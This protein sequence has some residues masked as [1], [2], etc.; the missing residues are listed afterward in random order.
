MVLLIRYYFH[1]HY[2]PLPPPT[3]CCQ[4][5][6]LTMWKHFIMSH[7]LFLIMCPSRCLTRKVKACSCCLYSVSSSITLGFWRILRILDSVGRSRCR[8][9]SWFW[10]S[11]QKMQ[12]PEWYR[13]QNIF[14]WKFVF[15]SEIWREQRTVTRKNVEIRPSSVFSEWFRYHYQIP[16]TS[17]CFTSYF[18]EI[19]QFSEFNKSYLLQM[20][21]NN[22]DFHFFRTD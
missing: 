4:V 20:H 8:G 22:F 1:S 9:T 5:H 3:L 6:S 21:Q 7:S 12:K 2:Y 10:W 18:R 16:T 15:F 11:H 14:F 13:I 17:T 19:S